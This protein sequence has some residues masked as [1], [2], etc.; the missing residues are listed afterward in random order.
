MK[1][2]LHVTVDYPDD[3]EYAGGPFSADHVDQLMAAFAQIGIHR[4]YWI[5]YHPSYIR[6]PLSNGGGDL[7]SCAVAAAHRH[8]MEIYGLYKPFETG[9]YLSL[10]SVL[11]LPDDLE[12][13]PSLEGL[14][15][16]CDDFV[17]K[18]PDF[19]IK[20][21]PLQSTV[22]EVYTITL[23]KSDASPTRLNERN[24]DIFAG[25]RNGEFHCYKGPFV[26]RDEVEDRHGTAARVLTLTGLAIDRE[27]RYILVSSTLRD[28][29]PDF[30]NHGRDMMTLYDRAGREIPATADEGAYG[31]NG[32]GPNLE[33]FVDIVGLWRYGDP[34]RL[35]PG[36][37][38]D[39]GEDR[40][41]TA[42]FFDSDYR[43]AKTQR[44]LDGDGSFSR[45]DGF[46]ARAIGKNEYLRGAM[47]PVYPEVRAYW[48]S[49]I[50]AMIHAGVDGV[51]IRIC[52]HSSW[53]PEGDAYG[54]NEPV[55]REF[56]D[57]YGVDILNEDFNREDWRRLQGDHFT[58][59]LREAKAM[60]ASRGLPLQMHISSM[61]EHSPFPKLNNLPDNFEWQWRKWIE[62]DIADSVMLKYGWL[63]PEFAARVARLARQHRKP[64]FNETRLEYPTLSERQIDPLRKIV[65]WGLD[66]DDVDGT[67]LYEGACF[68][69]LD[70]DANRV[71][72]NPL[73]KELLK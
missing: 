36:I 12:G 53:T 10:P 67:V 27:C 48:L 19:R 65:A 59:F 37:P 50:D 39:Y 1:K 8:G 43:V 73:I 69:K 29:N 62:E 2:N 35:R 68:T 5:Y 7:M 71:V 70:R 57:R 30:I 22:G 44:A 46:V 21:Q 32:S 54:F 17:L 63:R 4:V 16:L 42:C 38:A 34:T 49:N 26:F 25:S 23:T 6:V 9:L 20:R 41:H 40:A 56:H 55:V 15:T 60:L 24:L 58:G 3:M 72:V 66:N 61:I 14:H 13:L 31:L 45:H 11:A 28:K 52:N 64:V 47:H 18:H 33:R 51:D